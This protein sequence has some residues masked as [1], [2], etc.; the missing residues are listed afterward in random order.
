MYKISTTSNG[1]STMHKIAEKEFTLEDFSCEHL[2]A[3]S[4]EHFKNTISLLNNYR[5]LYILKTDKQINQSI[6]MSDECY[7]KYKKDIWWQMIQLLPSS[8]NQKRTITMNY[9]VARNIIKQRRNHKL[10][11]WKQFL[12]SLKD[13]PYAEEL[14]F[15]GLEG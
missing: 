12:D 15:Y 14:L 13:L 9:A 3:Q 2:T 6:I 11:E 1:C 7:T 4:I 10:D 5:S 8:Y